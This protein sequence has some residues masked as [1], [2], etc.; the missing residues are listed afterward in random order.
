MGFLNRPQQKSSNPATKFLEW[1]SNE[2][3]FSY[4]D[5][6]AQENVLVDIPFKFLVMEEFHTVKG[7][8]DADKKYI[9]SNEVLQVGTDVLT[10][11]TYKP[12]TIAQGVYKEIKSQIRDAGG[13][14]CKSM[15]VMLEDGSIVNIMLKGSAISEWSEFIG[16]GAW[17][18]LKDEWVT[19][20]SAE[21]KK[22]GAT[23]YYVPKFK[24]ETSLSDK[25]FK[26]AQE[27]ATVLKEYFDSY[28]GKDDEAGEEEK[29]ESNLEM[30]DDL[31]F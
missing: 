30:A 5:K 14:Y 16:K 27:S 10:V 9:W 19:I 25:D 13:Y 15:Y 7:W 3:K 17:K 20:E 24:F 12:R 1:K 8:N 4:Y 26:M 18:R 21:K 6:E 29:A 31:D 2:Q 28:F 22:K 23:V 11:K